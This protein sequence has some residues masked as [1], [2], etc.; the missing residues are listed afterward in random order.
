MWL[1]GELERYRWGHKIFYLQLKHTG[2]LKG[3]ALHLHVMFGHQSLQLAQGCTHTSF[4]V[5]SSSPSSKSHPHV[6]IPHLC[7]QQEGPP[8]HSRSHRLPRPGLLP[9][10]LHLGKQEAFGPNSLHHPPA[11]AAPT[12]Q[13]APWVP[14]QVRP[15]PRFLPRLPL[16][17]HFPRLRSSPRQDKPPHRDPRHRTLAGTTSGLSQSPHK[18]LPR[19][20]ALDSSLPPAAT[21]ASAGPRTLDTAP[22]GL[23]HPSGRRHEK[24]GTSS[25]PGRR[26]NRQTLQ[27][28]AGRKE[29]PGYTAPTGPHARA[30][31]TGAGRA[32]LGVRGSRALGAA[33][34]GHLPVLWCRGH[35]ADRP[36]PSPVG[37][38]VA[39]RLGRALGVLRRPVLAVGSAL[40]PEAP[41]RGGRRAADERPRQGGR[42]GPRRPPP[43]TLPGPRPGLTWRRGRSGSGT[44]GGFAGCRPCPG[45][46]DR[47]VLSRDADRLCAPPPTAFIRPAPRRPAPSRARPSGRGGSPSDAR[48]AGGL[49]PREA[50]GTGT[51][52]ATDGPTPRGW[53]RARPVGV[54]SPVSVEVPEASPLIGRAFAGEGGRWREIRPRATR[55]LAARPSHWS[56]PGRGP[57]PIGR[58]GRR[59]PRWRERESGRGGGGT[60]PEAPRACLRANSRLHPTQQSLGQ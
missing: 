45:G 58:P 51:L 10:P 36:A 37:S 44:W 52:P 27:R 9:C 21:P 34:G 56:Q 1:T 2:D 54:A 55:A 60:A 40:A 5:I 19:A 14:P 26:E 57:P 53:L 47:R 41:S 30:A 50:R 24:S 8:T 17:A 22:H 4:Q 42:A 35:A 7:A 12:Q 33:A 29:R 16:P 11:S 31:R 59:S 25:A 15:E 23:T 48:R 32:L 3:S 46:G 49:G 18:G 43:R 28:A 39:R 20:W 13:H 6:L 38:A